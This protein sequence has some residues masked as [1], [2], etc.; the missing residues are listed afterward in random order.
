MLSKINLILDSKLKKIIFIFFI[1]IT[2][3]SLLEIISLSLVI[4]LITLI[5][6]ENL[7]LDFVRE[8]FS[9]LK[10]YSNSKIIFLMFFFLG[11]VYFLKAIFFFLFTW[12]QYTYVAKIESNL[13]QS[14]YA[15][16]LARPYKFFTEVNSSELIRN[17]TEEVNKF[18]YYIINNGLSLLLEIIVI[19][20][21]GTFLLIYE[22]KATIILLILCSLISLLILKISNSK[23]SK[24]ALER[25]FH[26]KMKIKHIL[27][28]FLKLV[29]FSFKKK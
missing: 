19:F 11:F 24:W 21:I 20:F 18:T 12:M 16:Y 25:Q 14:L 6:N 15:Y 4:P 23:V 1:S 26:S 8:N 9:Y 28:S 13:S 2:L 22:T 10:N 3:V 17:I 27:N 5:L 29:F 7:V